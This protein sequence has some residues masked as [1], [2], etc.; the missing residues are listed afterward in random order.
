MVATK[1]QKNSKNPWNYLAQW[2]KYQTSKLFGTTLMETANM[3]ITEM[4]LKILEK[5]VKKAY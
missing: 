4:G 5:T 2:R 1:K 3:N